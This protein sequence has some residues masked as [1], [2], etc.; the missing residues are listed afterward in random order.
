MNKGTNRFEQLSIGQ[1]S[2]IVQLVILEH[3]ALAEGHGQLRVELTLRY[4]GHA[5]A[6]GHHVGRLGI[7]ERIIGAV[8]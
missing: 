6:R 5:G 2:L 7:V 4:D 1:D 3:I 8:L